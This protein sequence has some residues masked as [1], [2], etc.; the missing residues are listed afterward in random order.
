MKTSQTQNAICLRVPT[1]VKRYHDHGNSHK[2]HLPAGPGLHIS[3]VQSIFIMGG[4]L[5]PCRQ[6]G[7]W[8]S[9][10]FYI[11]IKKKAGEDCFPGRQENSLKFYSQ[12]DI[13]PPTR[14]YLLIVILSGPNMCKPPH[15][16]PWPPLACSNA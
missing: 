3:E 4:S 10:K 16:T 12:S 14:P 8:R 2:G 15:S 1:A 13:L 11:F 9:Q 7:H 6:T 5:A